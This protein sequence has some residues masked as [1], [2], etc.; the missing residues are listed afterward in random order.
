MEGKV[1]NLLEF[2]EKFPDEAA[3]EGYLIESR[4]PDGYVCEDCGSK[5]AWYLNGRRTFQCCY[6]NSQRSITADTLFHGSHTPLR[7]WFLA[8]YLVTESKK[9][10]SI[11]ELAHH[12]GMKD[13]RRAAR[14]K[15][16]IQEAM[17]ARNERYLLNGFIELDEA[18]FIEG[19]E[20]TNVL[21]AVSLE[22]ETGSPKY[23]RF[24]VV[25]NL[26]ATTLESAATS[27]I[28]ASSDIATD[29]FASHNGLGKLFN[30]HISCRQD[31]P[32]DAGEYLPWVHVLIS[33]AKRFI[34]GT[35]HAVNHLQGYLE[36]FSWR[37]NRRFSNLF[38]RMIA[39]SISYKPVYLPQ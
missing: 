2:H 37:F 19:G 39:T 9:G 38:H 4:W 23:V 11:L 10:I 3:C 5:E 25:E 8:F 21:V 16:L 17:T 18:V 24:R 31:K 7:E 20:N 36:E 28:E 22:E 15:R 33:N 12:L 6:C 27:C 13:C 26:K 34:N 32:S 1:L 35:H 14:M 30:E 29:A